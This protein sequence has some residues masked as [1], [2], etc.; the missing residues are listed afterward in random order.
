MQKPKTLEQM[1]NSCVTNGFVR[2]VREL[3]LQKVKSIM[4]N[5]D[6]DISS[7]RILMR[8]I[9]KED[10]EWMTVYTAYYEAVRMLTEALLIFDRVDIN[11]HQCLFS[12]LCFKHPEFEFDWNFFE[13]IRAKRHGVNYYG[14]QIAYKDWKSIEV[15][16]NLYISAMREEIE[17]RLKEK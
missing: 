9:K 5:A 13:K 10:R 3:N 4:A 14:E 11:N 15:Q 1:Y 16:M 6:T 12:Y 8:N 7:A 2:E 17:K